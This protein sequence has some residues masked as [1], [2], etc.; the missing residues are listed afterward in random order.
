[1]P[2][3]IMSL[4]RSNSTESTCT[5]LTVTSEDYENLY[6][7]ENFRT[8]VLSDDALRNI[9]SPNRARLRAADSRCRLDDLLI[10]LLE[11]APHPLGQRYIALSLHVAHQEGIDGVIDAAKAWLDGMLLPSVFIYLSPFVY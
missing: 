2:L 7:N 1:M 4:P 10:A 11:H 6:Y 8:E 9:I 5:V 3:S